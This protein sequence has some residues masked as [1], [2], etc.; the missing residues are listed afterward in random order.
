MVEEPYRTGTMT[1]LLPSSTPEHT[2]R[3]LARRQV[4]NS[5]RATNE[6]PVRVRVVGS[7]PAR[8]DGTKPWYVTYDTGPH[9]EVHDVHDLFD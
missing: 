3:S 9:G 7:G 4:I 1:V 5:L 2:V 6:W 8:R